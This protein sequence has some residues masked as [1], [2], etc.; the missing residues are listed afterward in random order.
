MNKIKFYDLQIDKKY[1]IA[2]IYTLNII[3]HFFLSGVKYVCF[4]LGQKKEKNFF[5]VMT[6]T[7]EA[8]HVIKFEFNRK[9]YIYIS[10]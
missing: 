7:L 3:K 2:W 9:L 8:F 5:K 1:L 10:T 6:L 4:C